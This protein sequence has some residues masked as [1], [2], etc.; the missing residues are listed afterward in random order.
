MNTNFTP[1]IL[2]ASLLLICFLCLGT[3]AGFAQ[4]KTH[5]EDRFTLDVTLF[6]DQF[7]G[8]YPYFS[9]AYKL[10]DTFDLTF[11]GIMWAGGEGAAWGNW[12]EFG[13]GI[14]FQAAEGVYISPQLG[15]LGGSLLSKGADGAGILGDGIVPNVTLT[16][17]KARTEGE[18]AVWYYAP[19]RNEAPLGGTTLSYLHYLANYGY[20]ATDFFSFGAHYEHLI[21]TGGS[22]IASASTE[23]Q[24][25]GAYVQFKDPKGGA[26]VRFTFGTDLYVGNESFYRLATGFRF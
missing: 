20:K 4:Q 5:E 18:A 11:Y 6:S 10:N 23:L 16:L 9:G 7:W 13:V 8:F 3:S 25:L 15:I 21:N 1:L 12:T 17:K 19:L 2:G 14:G 24:W 26:F 22:A